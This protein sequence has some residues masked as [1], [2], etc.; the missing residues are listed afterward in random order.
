MLV[1]SEASH[2]P[3]RSA[4][5]RDNQEIT[6]AARLLGCPVY[7]IPADFSECETAENALWHVPEQERETPAVW[8]GFIPAAERYEAVYQE[9]RRKRIHLLNT[10]EQHLTALEFDRSYPLR[11][12][13]AAEL[14]G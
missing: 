7:H 2:E 1:L 8:I 14:P 9:A 3:P 13:R 4:S 5:A 10:P 6:E 12:C 11:P